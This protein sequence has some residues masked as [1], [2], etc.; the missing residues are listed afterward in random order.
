MLLCWQEQWT[1][2]MRPNSWKMERDAPPILTPRSPYR[3][4]L[5][6][7]PHCLDVRGLLGLCLAQR[8]GCRP[9]FLVRSH[10]SFFRS[11]EELS[12]LRDLCLWRG[13]GL[14]LC[15][16]QRLLENLHFFGIVP[17]DAMEA[18]VRAIFATAAIRFISGVRRDKRCCVP[19]L[20]NLYRLL[21]P[22]ETSN[23]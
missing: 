23:L 21:E 2:C 4:V 18:W 13:S 10:H 1:S 20:L 22:A 3:E 14:H 15:L 5:P 6:H 7:M 11:L 12:G 9:Y 19:L 8:L 17:E 16:L